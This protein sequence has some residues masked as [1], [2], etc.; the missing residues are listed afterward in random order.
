MF[1]NVEI[2]LPRGVKFPKDLDEA[3]AYYVF[4]GYEIE[5]SP[6][7]STILSAGDLWDS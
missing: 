7:P 2:F 6:G 5:G 3:V 1:V 4:L